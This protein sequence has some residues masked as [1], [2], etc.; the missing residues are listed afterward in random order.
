M[1]KVKYVDQNIGES[2]IIEEY[3]IEKDAEE[4][5]EKQLEETKGFFEDCEYDYGDFGNVTKIWSK[6]NPN[7]F[8]SW[9]RLW[10]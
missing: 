10:K 8:S 7:E 9:E 4:A 2:G 3:S 5:I 6:N 1:F